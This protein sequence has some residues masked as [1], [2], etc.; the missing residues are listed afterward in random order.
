MDKSVFIVTHQRGFE[1]D[2]VMDELRQRNINVFRFNT[3]ASTKVSLTSF[4]SEGGKVEFLCD[5]RKIA[6][7]DIS[8]GWCQQL[9]PYLGQAS[10]ER[11]CLQRENLLTLQLA[12]FDLLPIRWFNKP[13]RV[14]HASNKILQL[15]VAQSVGLETPKTLVSND[16][17]AIRNFARGRVVVA[18]NLATPWMVRSSEET[19]AAYTR[20]VDPAWLL[21]DNALSFAP[22]IYQE[23]H[24]RG[25]DIRVVVVGGKTFSASCVPG[26]HQRE[27]VRREVGTGK[28]Y[29]PCELEEK[30]L[31]KLNTLT[32]T[33]GLDYCAA[34][35]MEDNDENLFFLEAN[36]CGAWW[37]IDRLYDGAICR[38]LADALHPRTGGSA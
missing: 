3:D 12:T 14:L 9:P 11:D 16:P 25:R 31:D 8:I 36:T 19:R 22:V 24:E 20:I 21:D 2:P 23:Y 27:D 17:A 33:L 32:R 15:T 28:S 26:P 4:F 29:E 35:F 13:S 5:G 30:T 18:K 38:A 6:S 34:D 1:A 7:S 37:W 10:T